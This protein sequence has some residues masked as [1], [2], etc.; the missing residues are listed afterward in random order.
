M[1]STENGNQVIATY[2]VMM[3]SHG[4]HSKEIH[5]ETDKSD[6]QKLIGVHFWGLQSVSFVC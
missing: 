2:M 4:D 3:P 5:A 1:F 6:E